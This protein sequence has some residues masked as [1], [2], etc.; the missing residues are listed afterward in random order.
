M[1]TWTVSIQVDNLAEKRISVTG[2]RTDGESVISYGPIATQVTGV[3]GTAR[4]IIADALFAKYEEE[5]Q[6]I[7]N[8]AVLKNWEDMTAALLDAKEAE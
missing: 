7:A 2:T 6:I 5:A 3:G 4:P 1:A 8:K